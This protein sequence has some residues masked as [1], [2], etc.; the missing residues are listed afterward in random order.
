[1]SGR[2]VNDRALSRYPRPDQ[3]GHI[4]RPC[5]GCLPRGLGS[6]RFASSA[7]GV[8]AVRQPDAGGPLSPSPLPKLNQAASGRPLVCPPGGDELP[9]QPPLRDGL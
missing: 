2:P 6:Q 3:R 7:A 8:A 4:R 1:M 5:A 9:V